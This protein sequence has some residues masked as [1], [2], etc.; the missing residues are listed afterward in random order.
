[1]KKKLLLL[2][3][4]GVV[5][6]NAQTENSDVSFVNDFQFTFGFSNIAPNKSMMGDAHQET[7]PYF[8]GRLGIFSYNR[9]TVGLHAEVQSMHVKSN[10]YF[11]AFDYTNVFTIGPYVSYFQPVS[12]NGLFEPYI[13]YDYANYTSRGDDKKLTFDSDGL[14]LGIDY[15]HK[16]GG[17][18]YVTFGVKYSIHKLRS[19]T[20]PAWEKYLNNYNFLSFKVGFTFA[21]NRL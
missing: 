13:S 11:G 20:N 5:K 15:E 16:I 17:K 7:F 10:S 12:A 14:G 4:L 9:F 8:T 6:A 21:K 18:A 2:M 3:L 1:M 19:Q